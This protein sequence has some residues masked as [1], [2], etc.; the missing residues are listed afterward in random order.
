MKQAQYGWILYGVT[1]LVE[2]LA[3]ILRYF[4]LSFVAVII[5]FLLRLVLAITQLIRLFSSGFSPRVAEET[6]SIF[7]GLYYVNEILLLFILLVSFAPL[8]LSI[9]SLAFFTNGAFF[10]RILLGAR[11][12][13]RREVERIRQARDS[14]MNNAP[15]DTRAPQ[16]Y[17]V[18]DSA[19]DNAFV[20]GTTLYLDRSLINSPH[21][22]A[23]LAHQIGH[24]NNND[25]KLQLA[26]RRL[27]LPPFYYVARSFGRVAP[28]I[29]LK[30]VAKQSAW[31][32]LLGGAVLF[33][34]GITA[35]VGG[36]VGL[37]LLTPFWS[38]Y[39]RNR[40]FE[41]DSFA[42]KVGQG[43]ALIQYLEEREQIFDVAVPFFISPNPPTE[44]RIDRL[45]MAEEGVQAD[46][47]AIKALGMPAQ[48]A[49]RVARGVVLGGTA[50][51]LALFLIGNWRSRIDGEYVLVQQCPS[52]GCASEDF[53][54]STFNPIIVFDDNTIMVSAHQSQPVL[55]TI[56][57]DS[58]NTM[59][60][61]FSERPAVSLN[62]RW[63]IHREENYLELRGATG[64]FRLMASSV[65]NS[66]DGVTP[67]AVSS[68][69]N[70]A[71]II[72]E[73]N[74]P[75]TNISITFAEDGTLYVD[76]RSIGTW[77][78]NTEG[79]V[80]LTPQDGSTIQV[81]YTLSGNTLELSDD[82]SNTLEGTYNR[83]T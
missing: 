14:V 6:A 26:L 44:E 22:T 23:V 51:I 50:L 83:V 65:Y 80:A 33:T 37:W 78:M 76:G 28:G 36:G 8:A 55:G 46:Q 54:I 27:V 11:D 34:S 79:Y 60:I 58:R 66:R 73:W 41:A 31:S 10:T 67:V 13:S 3:S 24:L 19:E 52:N 71:T 15:Q 57:Y 49:N 40:E 47:A 82:P 77:Q 59:N 2:L 45:M 81:R 38:S 75:N 5:A 56:T 30:G 4:F 68:G 18:M 48:E 20:V 74:N 17:Y 42:Q 64:V 32:I 16:A 69:E 21:L 25:G 12:P 43:S 63:S 1:L 62:G 72:G 70:N 61:D 29:V 39:W 7:G 53:S 35:L 9:Y